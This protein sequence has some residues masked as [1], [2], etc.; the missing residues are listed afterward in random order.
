MSRI[1]RCT[2][3]SPIFLMGPGVLVLPGG[4]EFPIQS[5]SIEVPMIEQITGDQIVNRRPDPDS[6]VRVV[7]TPGRRA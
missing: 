4:I 3:I 7:V 1:N 2:D 6:P 5:V